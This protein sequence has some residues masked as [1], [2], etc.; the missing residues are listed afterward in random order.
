M[1]QIVLDMQ[2]RLYADAIRRSL[3]QELEGY[4]IVISKTP[5]DTVLECRV[6]RPYALLM[7]IKTY[8]PW[9]FKERL[10]VRSKVKEFLSECKFVFIVEEA[11]R[12]GVVEVTKAKQSGL[13]DAFVFS[14]TSESYLA[15]VMDSL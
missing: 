13:I 11:D 7:E 4:N 3:V 10:G 14:S 5:Q 2:S 12:S 15:A 9:T 1:R 8:S 6:A